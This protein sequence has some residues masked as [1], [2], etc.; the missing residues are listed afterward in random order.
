VPTVGRSRDAAARSSAPATSRNALRSRTYASCW[1]AC[2]RAGC[3]WWSRPSA[4]EDDLDALL[5]AA[6]V[7][8]LIDRA[9]SS[10]DA[11][12]SKPEPDIVEAA[13]SRAGCDAGSVLMLGDTPFDVAAAARAGVRVVGLRCGGS[14]DAELAGAIAVYDDPAALLQRFAESPFAA[15]GV[16]PVAPAAG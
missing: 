13:L 5:E 11:E 7:A 3:N 2:G 1:N 6:G 8:D 14:G 10:D 16:E 9:T 15:S 12:E 4:A